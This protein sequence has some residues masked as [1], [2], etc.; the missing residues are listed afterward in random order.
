MN[1]CDGQEATAALRERLPSGGI[2]R[3][4]TG[5]I[6]GRRFEGRRFE[7]RRIEKRSGKRQ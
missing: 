7:G 5:W 3:L 4:R 2:G 6:E 1:G